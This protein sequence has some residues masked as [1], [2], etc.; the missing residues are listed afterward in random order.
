[1]QKSK[2]R[3]LIAVLWEGGCRV[4]ELGNMRVKD[5]EFTDDGVWVKFFW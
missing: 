1:L 2:N 5:V 4:E 3:A